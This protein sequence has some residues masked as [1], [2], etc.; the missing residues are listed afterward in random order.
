MKLYRQHVRR[1]VLKLRRFVA[2]LLFERRYG[3]K[4]SDVVTLGQL[5]LEHPDRTHY[6]P[7]GWRTLGK[8]LPRSEVSR[9]D[10]FVDLGSGMG[11]AVYLAAG[12]PFKRVLGVEIAPQ[13][14]AI[15]EENIRRNRARLE[16][17]DVQLVN[18]DVTEYELPDDVTIVFMFNPF[19]G[20]I[21]A[22]VM[23]QL[24]ASLDRVP[25]RLR[26][27]YGNPLEEQQVL[28]TGRATL[29]REIRNEGT[30]GPEASKRLCLYE[31]T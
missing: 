15:A 3:L 11:R 12:Y 2:W 25:R 13:L 5:G 22:S 1:V 31:L 23:E 6:G 18:A 7:T 29:A 28:A 10:V 4:T 30:E 14:H 21:F 26:L 24:L 17:K 20:A 9:D 27:I 8:I 16:C 19:G